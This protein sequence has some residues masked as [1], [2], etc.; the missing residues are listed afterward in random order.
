MRGRGSE[1]V[2]PMDEFFERDGRGAPDSIGVSFP[3][4]TMMKQLLPLVAVTALALVTPALQAKDEAAKAP[5]EAK[6]PKVAEAVNLAK[7]FENKLVDS[8]GERVSA[9]K[10]S[11]AKYV[12][13]YF[14]AHW[15][16]PCR[17]FTPQL[18]EFVKA[19]QKDGNFEVVFVSS[20]KDQ[21]AMLGYMT[22]TGMPWS[23]MYPGRGNKVKG[24]NEDINGIPHLRIYDKYDKI[25]ID[26]DYDA[27]IYPT[28]VLIKFKEKLAE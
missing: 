10:L 12:A 24:V 16:P 17:K 28:T 14:S 9:E 25:A 23:A 19:N 26:T 1:K 11:K 13:V 27:N 3:T 20:D 15:C 5:A 2:R 6:K 8:K 21:K 22:E 4:S 7:I 18:V